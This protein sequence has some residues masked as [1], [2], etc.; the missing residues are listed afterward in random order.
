MS[1]AALDQLAAALG[2]GGVLRP[3]PDLARYETGARYD[4]GRARAVLRPADTA[5]VAQAVAIA[6]QHRLRLIPQGANTG[7]VAGST[8]DS[9]GEE[10]VLSLE[11]LREVT[12]DTDNASVRA[13]AGVLLSELNQRLAGE[14]LCLPIDLGSDP[15]IGGMI[16]TNTGGA[17]FLRHGDVRAHVL[18]LTAV[19]PD[20]RIV[21]MGGGLR[22]DNTGPHWHHLLIGTS[23]AFGIVTEAELR[24]APV[25]CET[26]VA[27]LVPAGPEAVLSL[28]RQAERRFGRLLSAFE[29][30][31]REAMEAALAHVPSL[32]DPFAPAPLPDY[33]VMIEIARDTP[34]LLGE[35]ALDDLLQAGLGAIMEDAPDTL[36]DARFGRPE[37]GWALR[38][39][40]SEGVKASG[41]LIA[42]DLGFR[43]GD[44]MRF[45]ARMRAELSQTHPE[46]RL[47]DFG[48]IG[49]GGVHFNLVVPPASACATDPAA[50]A[51]LRD[52]IIR[53]AVEEYGGSFSAEHAIGRRNQRFRDAYADPTLRALGAAILDS[54]DAGPLGAARFD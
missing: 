25:D 36:A 51:A 11:R 4:H 2:P 1:D 38:H 17:R 39:A 44:T 43:R 13:G 52:R 30:M 45:C 20:G 49:D 48:H 8:P 54:F 18:G 40:L 28:L 34:A 23:G 31:S 5:G 35:P 29:G 9:S 10:L 53:V 7:L 22:K 12:I 14:G 6:A 47:C 19:L 15:S 16:A 50:E 37:H 3:G 42:F 46:A 24:L 33:A 26:A 21:A 32:R 27:L 41:K